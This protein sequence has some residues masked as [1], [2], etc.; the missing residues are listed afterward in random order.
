MELEEVQDALYKIITDQIQP[1][2]DES[3]CDG[4]RIDNIMYAC[5]M[6]LQTNVDSYHEGLGMI[7][8]MQHR[9]HAMWNVFF[10]NPDD[11]DVINIIN[12]CFKKGNNEADK[13]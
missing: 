9:F 5:I 8:D 12:N 10:E 3:C 6:L 4:H 2:I 1:L 7:T 11:Q 13:N